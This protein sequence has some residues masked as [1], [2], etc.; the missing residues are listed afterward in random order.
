MKAIAFVVVLSMVLLSTAALADAPG[1]INYQG[2]LTDSSG[3]ALDTT[4]SITFTIYSDSTGGS[5]IWNET[6]SAV[7]VSNG[8]FN[9]LLGSV[10]TIQDTIFNAVSRWLGVKVGGDPEIEPRK[11]IVSVGYAFWAA[12]PIQP[13]MLTQCRS[14]V[15]GTGRSRVTICILLC[16]GVL[17]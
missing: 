8:L 17:P 4:V 6:Q 5:K 3:T 7:V 1:L 9:V 16:Q 12:E 15:T 13:A 10:N 11:R 2:T 14:P